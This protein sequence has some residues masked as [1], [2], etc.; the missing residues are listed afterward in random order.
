MPVVPNPGTVEQ[1]YMTFYLDDVFI[2]TVHEG[3]RVGDKFQGADLMTPQTDWEFSPFCEMYSCGNS[4][5]CSPGINTGDY[6]VD[7]FRFTDLS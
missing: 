4:G 5:A 6:A 3:S 7:N 1:N 2:K